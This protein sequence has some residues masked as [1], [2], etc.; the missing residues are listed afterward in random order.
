M[1]SSHQSCPHE[2]AIARAAASGEW[3][4]ELRAHRDGCL[5]CAELTLVTA[6]LATDAEELL[7]DTRPL[8]DPD[9]IWVRAQLEEREEILKKATRGIAIVQRVAIAAVAAVLLAFAPTIWQAVS[10]TATAL[11]ASAPALDVPRAAG[12]PLLV[13]VMSMVVLGGLA[14]WEMTFAREG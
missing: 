4:E 7:G 8:P 13:I 12:S 5:T 1:T 10:A 14:L 3:S 2:D 11:Q 6:A 9:L